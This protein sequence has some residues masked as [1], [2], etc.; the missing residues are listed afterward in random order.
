[1]GV[2]LLVLSLCIAGVPSVGSPVYAQEP[3]SPRVAVAKPLVRDITDKDDFIG[4][5]QAAEEVSVQ[6]RVGGYLESI[7][8]QD[9]QFVKEGDELF[10][11]D[12]RPFVTALNQAKANLAVANASLVYAEA[13]FDRVDGLVKS[14]SQTVA[15]L[16]DRRRELASARAN[17][18]GSQAALDR[19]ELDLTYSRIVAPLSGRI[20]RHLI[21]VGNLVA[22][23]QTT[24][25][26]IV[27][28]DPIDFYFDIDERRLLNYAQTA[29]NRAA[30]LQEGGGGLKVSV[31]L[32]DSSRTI[33]T[34][35]LDFAE[36]RVDPQTGTLRARARFANPNLVLQP[37]LFGRVELEGSNSYRAILI[38]DE[39]IGSDQNE[40][41]VFVVGPDNVVT[42]K[43]IR[44]GPKVAGYRV[45][46]S[47]LDGSER[48]VVRGLM[49]IR[50]GV[51]VDPNEVLL[52]YENKD[53]IEATPETA[54]KLEV[55]K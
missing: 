49:R 54:S 41:I 43:A 44:P 4:R 48:I 30:V 11:I 8:F 45:V 24:L 39:A 33:V 35:T 53:V 1:M 38:P 52:P 55:A 28:L 13:Q 22:A 37:G 21:S 3:S 9:G 31:T 47:G 6:A 18:Q 7:S 40:R 12:Q 27:M 34:G 19:A 16:D 32:N 25:T 2:R 5:F 42:T 29:R 23:D 46:R 14:G 51:K 20:D 26:S 15:T 36:N 17:V 50:P 10:R